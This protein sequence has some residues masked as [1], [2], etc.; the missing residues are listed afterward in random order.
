MNSK[1]N[2]QEAFVSIGKDDFLELLE[3]SGISATQLP[4]IFDVDGNRVSLPETVCN[5]EKLYSLKE[6][7]ELF[8][9]TRDTMRRWN[10]SGQ[11]KNIRIPGSNRVYYL[12]S[13][14]LNCFQFT[15]RT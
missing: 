4:P 3:S 1:D 7:C 12:E 5:M 6:V 8:K 15:K 14:L 10:K 9:V 11:L 13:T 2:F